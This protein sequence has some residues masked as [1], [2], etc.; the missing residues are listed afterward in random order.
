MVYLHFPILRLDM[1]QHSLN[2][3]ISLAREM[4]DEKVSEYCVQGNPVDVKTDI[5]FLLKKFYKQW[6]LAYSEPEILSFLSEWIDDSV[7]EI[8]MEELERDQDRQN[9]EDCQTEDD[10]WYVEAIIRPAG[11]RHQSPGRMGG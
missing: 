8:K 11:E 7:S 10:R 9:E 4:V 1:H 5:E 2:T 6:V 3:L